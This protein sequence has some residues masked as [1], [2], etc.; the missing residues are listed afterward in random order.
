MVEQNETEPFTRID[1]HEAK[2]LI[3]DGGVQIVDS[4]EPDEHADGH[5]PGSIN[6]P[7]MSTLPRAGELADDRPVLFFCKVG[8]RSAVAAEFAA[9]VGLTDLF[10][11]EGGHD[12]WSEAGYELE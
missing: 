8:Q 7:H 12:A 10:N 2:R 3:D 11:V 1:V 4:R 9:S 5:V 6:I